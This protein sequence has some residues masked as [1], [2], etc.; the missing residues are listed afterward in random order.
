MRLCGLGGTG[1]ARCSPP[2]GRSNA[3][4]APLGW[5]PDAVSVTICGVIHCLWRA[6]DPEGEVLQAV[7]TPSNDTSH[8]S[9]HETAQISAEPWRSD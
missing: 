7:L 3:V 4:P 9:D 2:S 1:P 5:H 6:V 8:M